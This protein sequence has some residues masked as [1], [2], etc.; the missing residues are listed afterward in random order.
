MMIRRMEESCN[1]FTPMRFSRYGTR[2]EKGNSTSH[3]ASVLFPTKVDDYFFPGC[4]KRA[5]SYDSARARG[6]GK[7]QVRA[8]VKHFSRF[9]RRRCRAGDLCVNNGRSAVRERV[10][11]LSR[12]LTPLVRK[13]EEKRV[14]EKRKRRRAS[15]A[16][17]GHLS[18]YPLLGSS[19]YRILPTDTDRAPS[20]RRPRPQ[21]SRWSLCSYIH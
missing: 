9:M 18:R 19:F 1:T 13:K 7:G 4:K 8:R 2:I 15:V 16:G 14:E 10:S 20:T 5:V 21:L 12:P 17:G 6:G 11:A 3:I